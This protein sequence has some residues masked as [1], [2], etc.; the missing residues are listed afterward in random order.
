[1]SE[2]FL[3]PGL[4]DLREVDPLGPERYPTDSVVIEGLT[5]DEAPIVHLGPDRSF[6]RNVVRFTPWRLA[7]EPIWREDRRLWMFRAVE[8]FSDW[9]FD[10]L[11]GTPLRCEV[12]HD[13]SRDVAVLVRVLHDA[14]PA[15]L[16]PLA[17]N[18]P[19]RVRTTQLGRMVHD[20]R[21]GWWSAPVAWLDEEV[22][23]SV[24][25]DP[26]GPSPEGIRVA[27]DV[28][29]DATQLDDAA[30]SAFTNELFDLQDEGWSDD[31]VPREQFSSRPRSTGLQVWLD[32]VE[33][34][35]E[36]E[37]SFTDHAVRVAIGLD[38]TVRD[39][40]LEG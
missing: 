2:A 4:S 32:E 26:D 6:N 23:L 37:R 19:D 8:P 7:G 33:L 35:Y 20:V 27:V 1:M 28:L 5:W 22:I 3:P 25:G 30:R 18:P 15:D 29:A 17:G 34:W 13:P 24:E 14:T 31:P 9:Y 11:P 38:G 40:A 36:D 12:W 16:L 39:V 21:V 10:F